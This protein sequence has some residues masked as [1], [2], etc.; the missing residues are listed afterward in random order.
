MPLIVIGDFLVL[1]DVRPEVLDVVAVLHDHVGCLFDCFLVLDLLFELQDSLLDGF[2]FLA[3]EFD[4]QV[5]EAVG[6]LLQVVDVGDYV[7]V[8]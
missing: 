3:D 5:H 6:A 7:L 2:A 1:C 4:A 8:V